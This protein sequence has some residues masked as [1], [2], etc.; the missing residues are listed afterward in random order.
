MGAPVPEQRGEAIALRSIL[1]SGLGGT[2]EVTGCDLDEEP[3]HTPT[4]ALRAKQLH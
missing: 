3:L 2:P 1:F 4:E